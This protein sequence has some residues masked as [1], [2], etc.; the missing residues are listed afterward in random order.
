MHFVTAFQENFSGNREKVAKVGVI[1]VLKVAK[2]GAIT[3]LKV[4]Y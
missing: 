4:A 2:V 1:T 3:V